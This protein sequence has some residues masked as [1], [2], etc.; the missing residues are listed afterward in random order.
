[1]CDDVET[2]LDWALD[3][4][5]GK[6]V[7]GQGNDFSLA[8]DFRDRFQIN[9]FQQRITRR[10][11]PD[12]ARVWF[13]C[14]L[15]IFRVS[16]IDIGKIKIRRAAPHSIKQPKRAAVKVIARD[17]M[18]ATFEQLEHCRHRSQTGCKGE[19]ARSAFQIG[20]AL[21]IG[22]PRW[23]NRPRVIVTFMFSR[24]FLHVR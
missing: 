20:N 3:P 16:Q 14:A 5:G 23:I 9:E 15:E 12:H 7:V 10:F 4:W 21:F 11:D 17:D 24:A 6:C 8:R 19:P 13:N 1:M 22:Q 18:R 2:R